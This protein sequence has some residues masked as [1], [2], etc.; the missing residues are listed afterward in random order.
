M[1]TVLVGW[2]WG[3]RIIDAIAGRVFASVGGRGETLDELLTISWVAI[4][5]IVTL[6]LPT[7]ICQL[8]L[9]RRVQLAQDERY[10]FVVNQP[11]VAASSPAGNPF[12]AEG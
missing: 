10:D 8:L 9:V 11:Q 12:A 1:S 7:Q 6:D 2:W 3:L 5:L 4:V